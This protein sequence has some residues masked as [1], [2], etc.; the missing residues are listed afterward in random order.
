MKKIYTLLAIMLTCAL[1]SCD[2]LTEDEDI[3]Y[4]L[5]GTWQGEMYIKST[6]G[7]RTYNSTYS[8]VTFLK[9]PYRYSN[10]DGYWVDY[11]SDAPWDYVANHISWRVDNGNIYVHF[12]E[13]GTSVVISDYRLS[14]SRFSGY[15]ADGDYDIHFNLTHISSPNWDRYS[16]WGYD[17]WYDEYYYAR[18]TRGN[19]SDTT[20]VAPAEKPIRQ[21]GKRV[22]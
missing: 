1:T 21:F 19:G 9:D 7:S 8:E 3:A 16:H 18:Q 10:G 13:E 22:E 17:G 14:N 15:I 6:W 5:E 20:G 12:R 4:T 11:Y 2:W